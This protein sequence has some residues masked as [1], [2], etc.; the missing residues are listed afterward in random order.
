MNYDRIDL[1][2]RCQHMQRSLET[3]HAPAT[4][5]ASSGR[6]SNND[7]S[8]D[9]R[10]PPPHELVGFDHSMMISEGVNLSCSVLSFVWYVVVHDTGGGFVLVIS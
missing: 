7:Y 5:R 1:E 3:L 6:D 8:V 9:H 10:P 4:V 2:C